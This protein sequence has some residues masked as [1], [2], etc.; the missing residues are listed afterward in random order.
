MTLQYIILQYIASFH[1]HDISLH[2]YVSMYMFQLHPL[3]LRS[4]GWSGSKNCAA[5]PYSFGSGD[6]GI[7]IHK[8]FESVNVPDFWLMANIA[9]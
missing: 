8:I 7:N 2:K 5:E 3:H 1:L 9:F 6:L 4:L